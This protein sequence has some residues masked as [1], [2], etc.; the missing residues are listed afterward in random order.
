MAC[1]ATRQAE[2]MT[3]GE[4]ATK[5]DSWVGNMKPF[6]A[7]CSALFVA[8]VG[9]AFATETDDLQ[10][11]KLLTPPSDTSRHLAKMRWR[12]LRDHLATD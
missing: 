5:S 12:P 4:T 9:S 2:P 6:A 3:L 11:S 1:R 8:I 10:L 7:L